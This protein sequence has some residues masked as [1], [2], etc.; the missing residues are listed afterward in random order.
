MVI[1][2][3]MFGWRD[4]LVNVKPDTFIRWHRQGFRLLWRWKSRP[5][6][7]ACITNMGS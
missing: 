5:C 1:L 7:A 4:A 3:R 6:S 2:G